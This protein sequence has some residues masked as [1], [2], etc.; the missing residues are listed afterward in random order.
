MCN[1][2]A[3]EVE[4]HVIAAAFRALSLPAELPPLTRYNIAPTQIVLIVRESGRRELVPMRWGLIPHWAKD[5][6]SASRLCNARAET[7]AD[8]PSFRAAFRSRR[9]LVPA[10]GF[11]EWA[12]EGDR[13]PYLFRLRTGGLFTFAGLWEAW[14]DPAGAEA[15]TFSFVTTEANATVGEVHPRMPVILLGDEAERW[16]DPA[17]P[18]EEL[19]ALLRPAPDDLLIR[20][21]VTKLVNNPRNDL[22]E[23]V[24]TD[25]RT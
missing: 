15:L 2:F 13:R 16:I 11:Y 8:K 12:R 17:T 7:V 24:I 3:M 9:C 5:D 22:P 14:R 25:S 21:P 18:L 10:T 4:P 1:R 20:T 19:Q 6:K 23:C